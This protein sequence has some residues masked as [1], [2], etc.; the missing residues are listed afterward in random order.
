MFAALDGAVHGIANFDDL[1]TPFR[2]VAVDLISANQ[3]VLERGSLAQAMRATM[4][5]PGIF[6]PVEIDGRLLVDGG[7]MNNVPADVARSMGATVVMA[8]NV[9]ST[10]EPANGS[11]SMLGVI[12]NTIDA[13]MLASTRRGIAQADIVIKPELEEFGSLDWRRAHDLAVAGYQAAESMK[14]KLLPLALSA[15]DWQRYVEARRAKRRTTIATP[16]ALA[17]EGAS[18][19]D[20]RQIRML[21]EPRVGQQLDPAAIKLDIDTLSGLDAYQTIDWAL[22]ERE[23]QQTLVI[24]ATPKSYAPP[25]LM[26]APTLQNTTSEDFTFQLAGRYLAYDV[27]TSRSELRIDAAL[28]STPGIG[29]EFLPAHWLDTAVC[30]R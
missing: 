18:Q 7:A 4:S 14:D 20:E 1:P 28:G 26:L 11:S 16:A 12:A 21:L 24:R 30:V 13:M 5:L 19:A 22:Q 17:V 2:C 15:D 9:S 27:L 10:A 29:A 23:G 3:V 8:V 6:P 25:F